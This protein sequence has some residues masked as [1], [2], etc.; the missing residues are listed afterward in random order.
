ME[1]PEISEQI[2]DKKARR[3]F[4]QALERHLKQ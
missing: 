2:N 4:N 1:A 3:V